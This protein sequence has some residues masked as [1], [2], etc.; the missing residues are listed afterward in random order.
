MPLKDI[1]PW[2]PIVGMGLN[3]RRSSMGIEARKT[4]QRFC[5]V[6]YFQVFHKS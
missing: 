2:I 3:G 4:S 5:F 1:K 6:F